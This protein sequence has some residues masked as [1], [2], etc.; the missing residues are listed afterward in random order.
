MNDNL[1]EAIHVLKENG[2]IAI[3]ITEDM[4]SCFNTCIEVNG[5]NCG[6]CSGNVCLLS[7]LKH[8]NNT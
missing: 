3:Q 7:I 6:D 2:Y 5:G 1:K 4:E 8:K